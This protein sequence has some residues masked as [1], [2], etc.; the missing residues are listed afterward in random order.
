[1]QKRDVIDARCQV[2]KEIA[3]E[4]T[5][6]AIAFEFPLGTNYTTLIFVAAASKRLNRDRLA[7][8]IV[9]L[10][11]VIER[12][13]VAWSA[14]HEQKD[15]ALGLG[16]QRRFFGSQRIAEFRHTFGSDARLGEEMFQREKSGRATP[17]KPAPASHK[18]S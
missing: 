7:V 6:L 12:I 8:Q 1:M 18:N 15:H 16:V 14:V 3:D 9:Q 4:L 11:L 5:A 10:R 13:D 17:V 2:R